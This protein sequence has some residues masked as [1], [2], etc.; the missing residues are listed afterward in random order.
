MRKTAKSRLLGLALLSALVSTTVVASVSLNTPGVEIAVLSKKN[1][2]LSIE[3]VHAPTRDAALMMIEELL[4]DPEVVA[5][6]IPNKVSSYD[7]L[8]DVQVVDAES[9]NDPKRSEQWG[10]TRLDGENVKLE[11]DGSGVRVAV[12]DTGVEG[13][14]PD[15]E[16]AVLPGFDVFGD[17][18]GRVDLNGHGTHVAGI[19]A[20]QAD[21]GVGV[22]GLASGVEILPIRALDETGYG[23][24]AGI[25]EGILWAV[26]N[27]ADV[28]NLSLGSPDRD[29]VLAAAVESAISSG[30]TVVA[31]SGNDGA[32]GSPISYPAALPGVIAVA[33]TSF[34]DQK[35]IF[36]TS[37]D[38][39]TV[40]APG[41]SIMSTW[42]GG[43]YAYSSGTS[44]SAPFV[45]ASA[46]L[47]EQKLG[48]KGPALKNRLT[49]SA[50][51]AGTPGFDTSFGYGVVDPYAALTDGAPRPPREGGG[52]PGSPTIPQ[53][54]SLPPLPGLPAWELPALKPLP[55]MTRPELPAAP[56]LP[57]TPSGQMPELRLDSTLTLDKSTRKDEQVTFKI[58]LSVGKVTLGKRDLKVET[59]TGSSWGTPEFIVTDSFGEVSIKKDL[60]TG[61]KLRITFEGDRVGKT[62]SI[63][64]EAP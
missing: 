5:A 36:S 25:A 24:D 33:A 64:V 12:V 51:D 58:K 40:A 43:G 48:L 21:N 42:P 10:L 34:G 28:I 52:L 59:S 38:Y 47:V 37:G 54:P 4:E 31:S 14:H 17:S 45:S 15:L 49:S 3:R 63:E 2:E 30:V 7:N 20:A 57:E 61:E 41:V 44:M 50:T 62:S 60:K 22:A 56:T 6:S 23:D 8:T 39:V 13:S 16:H 53:L 9:F 27:D 35:A 29:P 19:I 1:G 18:D 55:P 46:A 26:Q 32:T 11:A